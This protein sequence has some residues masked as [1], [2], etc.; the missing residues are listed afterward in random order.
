MHFSWLRVFGLV[1]IGFKEGLILL[2]I[3][4]QEFAHFIKLEEIVVFSSPQAL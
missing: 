3:K 1:V 2:F 4:V